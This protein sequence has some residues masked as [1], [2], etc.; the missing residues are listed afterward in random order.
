MMPFFVYDAPPPVKASPMRTLTWV[1]V[2]PMLQAI[3]IVIALLCMI[4][5][6]IFNLLKPQQRNAVPDGRVEHS[7]RNNDVSGTEGRPNQRS[8]SETS[9]GVQRLI[10]RL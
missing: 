8:A 1:L 4:G 3:A 5:G 2:S 6:T 10:H 9:T 7:L